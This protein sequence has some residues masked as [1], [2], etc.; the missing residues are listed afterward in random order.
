M[1]KWKSKK[2]V[3][4]KVKKKKNALLFCE[5]IDHDSYNLTNK[6]LTKFYEKK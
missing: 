4:W 1:L 6:S 5:K 2:K 3:K